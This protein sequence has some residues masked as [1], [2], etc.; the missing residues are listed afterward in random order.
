M[1]SRVRTIAGASAVALLLGGGAIAAVTATG[2]T[3]HPPRA[4]R[5]HPRAAQRTGRDVRAASSYLGVPA[6]QLQAQLRSGKS[7]AQVA[8]ATRGR[9]VSG[10]VAAVI[11]ERRGR[12]AHASATLPKRVQAE[13]ERAGGP[14][15]PLAPVRARRDPVGGLFSARAFIGVPAAA[16]LGISAQ[17][18][19]RELRAGRSLADIAHASGRSEAVLIEVITAS[20]K[21]EIS[22][23]LAAGAISKAREQA[24]LAHLD[25]RVHGLVRRS[26]PGSA[27]G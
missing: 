7:L 10:L 3:S 1:P 24:L 22:S 27:A 19:R 15:S 16:Y 26:F 12:L 5:S 6:A 21:R 4:Q 11:A 23:Q 9:S 8:Q 20:A 14:G 17:E 2:R 18:L 25:K 13:V